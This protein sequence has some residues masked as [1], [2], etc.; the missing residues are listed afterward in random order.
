MATSRC[1]WNAAISSGGSPLNRFRI[2]ARWRRG[3]PV[4]GRVVSMTFQNAGSST[5]ALSPR[6]VV[7]ALDDVVEVLA[8]RHDRL[9]VGEPVGRAAEHGLDGVQ[10]D[11]RAAVAAGAGA[12]ADHGARQ[13]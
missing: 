1:R 5:R 11:A 13:V 4:A 10:V 6:L 3:P 9:R 2:S 12:V 7:A 8:E